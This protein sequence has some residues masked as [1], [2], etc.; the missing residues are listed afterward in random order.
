MTPD[1]GFES[2]QF[3]VGWAN[4]QFNELKTL[5][6][7]FLDSGPTTM[8][9]EFN[10]QTRMNELKVRFNPV[11]GNIRGKTSNIIKDLR[12]AL[13]QATNAATSLISGK[14]KRNA[15]FPFA[16]SPDD[17]DTAVARNQCKDIP[18]SL[19][20][21]LKGYEPYPS[22]D[23]W[24]GGNNFLRLLGRVSGPNKHR[25][26]L[27]ATGDMAHINIQ[28]KEAFG[29]PGEFSHFGRFDRN[30]DYVV[31]AVGPNSHVEF[32][33][34]SFHCYVSFADTKLKGIPVTQFLKANCD[35]VGSIVQ[36]LQTQA[37]TIAQEA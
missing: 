2:A 25:F 33:K 9:K 31:V 36:D 34:I 27:T 32:E 16:G 37:V 18:P 1:E 6:E 30:G 10:N 7:A 22:G 35:T 21:T 17:F 5:I 14:T 26:T 28:I 4:T 29:P 13:D 8:V 24:S 3:L 15:H 11:P 23:G 20:A 19:H 12:D